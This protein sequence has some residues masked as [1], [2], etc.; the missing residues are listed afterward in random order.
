MA[1]QPVPSETFGHA[2]EN[3]RRCCAMFFKTSAGDILQASGTPVRVSVNKAIGRREG[4][5]FAIIFPAH[6]VRGQRH[7]RRTWG[8]AEDP[9]VEIVIGGADQAGKIR[10]L[11]RLQP[12]GRT[13]QE[14]KHYTVCRKY[15]DN[16]VY[17]READWA[18]LR[19][20]LDWTSKDVSVGGGKYALGGPNGFF[21]FTDIRQD[22]LRS[23]INIDGIP[24]PLSYKIAGFPVVVT[25]ADHKKVNWQMLVARASDSLL[26]GRCLMSC[27]VAAKHT[28]DGLP[29]TEQQLNA[30]HPIRYLLPP[31][32]LFNKGWQAIK[33]DPM[34]GAETV[35]ALE[36]R[37][38]MP[39]GEDLLLGNGAAVPEGGRPKKGWSGGPWR[40]VADAVAPTV[41]SDSGPGP[42]AI[43]V[44]APG[45]SV[46]Q[47]PATEAAVDPVAGA[48]SAEMVDPNPAAPPAPSPG[49]AAACAGSTVI[50]MHTMRS[51]T[52]E[53]GTNGAIYSACCL[54][55][56]WVKTMARQL[57]TTARA[58]RHPLVSQA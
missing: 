50:G 36:H 10:V 12:P 57:A 49:P 13:V 31:I 19:V 58:D 20:Q 47:A 8:T 15:I 45:T 5:Y 54:G 40:F 4:K 24:K 28:W 55:G 30:S 7:R 48:A 44:S 26:M 18:A 35:R 16:V 53:D 33:R 21:T 39:V 32:R 27:E 22:E 41:E 11:W 2:L 6:V 46:S 17:R 37:A 42:T 29:F 14:G 52:T 56:S 9:L 43:S 23:I 1:I 38:Q 3:N 51:L 34:A 25:N